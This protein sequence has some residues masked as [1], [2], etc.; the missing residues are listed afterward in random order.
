MNLLQYDKL[1][2]LS[3]YRQAE[4]LREA[5]QARLVRLVS[6][7]Q[8][9]SWTWLVRWWPGRPQGTPPPEVSQARHAGTWLMRQTHN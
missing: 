2:E 5:E 7:K 3:R 4:F 9:R 6:P 1:W 8:P